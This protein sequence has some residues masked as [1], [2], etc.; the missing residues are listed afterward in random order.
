MASHT[1]VAVVEAMDG[2][3][4]EGLLNRKLDELEAEQPPITIVDIKVSFSNGDLGNQGAFRNLPNTCLGTII[5]RYDDP[6]TF[7]EEYH[8]HVG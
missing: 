4:L 7:D 2:E 3:M 6:A 5:Y 1:R 8:K